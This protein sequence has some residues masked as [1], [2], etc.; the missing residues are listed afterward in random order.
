MS[1]F[2]L[3]ERIAVAATRLAEP[4]RMLFEDLFVAGLT[5]EEVCERRQ[6]TID[7]FAQMYRSMM[8][9][10]CGM[11]GPGVTTTRLPLQAEGGPA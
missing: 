7:Q 2:S 4:E 10:L 6:L 11:T 5:R 9:S 3:L 8:R 1:A